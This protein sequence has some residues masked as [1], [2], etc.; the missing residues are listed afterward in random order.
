MTAPSFV[1]HPSLADRRAE[2]EALAAHVH[3]GDLPAGL[4]EQCGAIA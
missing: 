4:A 3:D 1:R 2:L